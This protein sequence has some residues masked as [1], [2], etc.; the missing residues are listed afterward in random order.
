MLLN[1]GLKAESEKLLIKTNTGWLQEE[2]WGRYMSL[3]V[4]LIAYALDNIVFISNTQFWVYFWY[5]RK[6]MRRSLMAELN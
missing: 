5:R 2:L 3:Y 4:V 1:W 6:N